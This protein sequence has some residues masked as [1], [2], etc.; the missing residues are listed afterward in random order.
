MER[1]LRIKVLLDEAA[2][3]SNKRYP[4]VPL[5]YIGVGWWR[6]VEDGSTWWSASYD[7]TSR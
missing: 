4:M 2:G 3:T 7:G 5:M 6:M 1:L